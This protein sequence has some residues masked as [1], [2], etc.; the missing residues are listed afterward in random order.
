MLLLILRRE[1]ENPFRLFRHIFFPSSLARS[2][3]GETHNVDPPPPVELSRY[4]N[5]CNLSVRNARLLIPPPNNVLH[6]CHNII[7]VAGKSR[8]IR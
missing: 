4:R 5:R 3:A 6:Y 8:V 1:H 7:V 2:L